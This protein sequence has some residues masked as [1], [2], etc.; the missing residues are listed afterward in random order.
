MRRWW[1]S[2][3]IL[4][5]VLV[6]AASAPATA[7][8]PTATVAVTPGTVP[9]H[10][11]VTITGSCPSFG[12]TEIALLRLRWLDGS[13]Y[14]ESTYVPL[15][16]DGDFV[17]DLPLNRGQ[18]GNYGVRLSCGERGEIV[19]DADPGIVITE[20]ALPLAPKPTISFPSTVPFGDDLPVTGTCPVTTPAA[21][22]VLFRQVVYRDPGT[23]QVATAEAPVAPDGSIETAV[24]PL[25]PDNPYQHGFGMFCMAGDRFLG[26]PVGGTFTV[27]PPDPTTSTST[28]VTTT[29]AASVP[30]GQAPGA[31]PVAGRPTFTG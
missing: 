29:S 27:A 7:Q 8:Q 4:A 18:T 30:V 6:A 24:E 19:A 25:L 26:R 28:A 3:G 22:R 2:V 13:G 16:D 1:R 21:D 17:L 31:R 14:G 12:P 10:G 23:D 20:P 5:V 9:V 15:L 11:T